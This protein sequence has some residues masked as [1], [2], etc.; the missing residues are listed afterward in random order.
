MTIAERFDRTLINTISMTLLLGG[1]SLL[2]WGLLIFLAQCAGWLKFG[3]WQSVPAYALWLNPSDQFNQL[4]PV[5]LWDTSWGPLNLVP[6]FA[7]GASL[8]EVSQSAGG[9]MAGLVKLAAAALD[10]P[11]S[12][13]CLLM[14]L[15]CI[16]GASTASASHLP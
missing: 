11:L 5:A 9:S 12:L 7:D 4:V 3:A 10:A 6:S 8:A 14:G 15:G 1:I 2:G 16:G 13:L